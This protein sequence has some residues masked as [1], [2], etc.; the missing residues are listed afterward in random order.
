MAL[1]THTDETESPANDPE[2]EEFEIAEAELIDSYVRDDLSAAER[3]LLEKG[4]RSSSRLAE[5][6]HFARMLATAAA[7]AR[8]YPA[9][10]SAS[11]DSVRQSD[12][13]G[14]LPPWWKRILG[15]S[16]AQRPAFQM[17][18]AGCAILVVL[19]GVALFVGWMKLR[20][21]S[22]HLAMERAAVEQQR[23]ELEKKLADQ[24]LSTEQLAAE[25]QKAR[26]QRDA[27]EKLIAKL[28][29]G[30]KRSDKADV[31]TTST[32]GN[33]FSP[34]ALIF[35]FPGSIRGSGEK[36]ELPV[37]ESAT[38]ITLNLVLENDEYAKYNAEVTNSQGARILQQKG[39]R[40]KRSP[41][42]P[43]LSL[44][45][46]S[47]LLPPGDS[48]VSITGVTSTGAVELVNYY[49]FRVTRKSK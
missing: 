18:L 25:L 13:E 1:L 20:S 15:F 46:S 17:A 6:L 48:S 47:R 11:A 21:E 33:T 2:S 14:A 40:P 26:Q 37:S 9:S 43:I 49:P 32:M 23:L 31:T 34:R 5:R 7:S 3:K 38:A 24:R 42:G 30:Q 8:T 4:L 35:L 45:V 29:Q 12:S 16:V 28:Q 39:L 10:D 44:Q 22:N 27:D 41:S 19:G 36:N